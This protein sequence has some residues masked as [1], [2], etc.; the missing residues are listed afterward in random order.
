MLCSLEVSRIKPSWLRLLSVTPALFFAFSVIF[1]GHLEPGYSHVNMAVSKLGAFSAE[2]TVLMN[3]FGLFLPGILISTFRL[4]SLSS[5]SAKQVTAGLLC[6]I[7]FGIMFAGL[8]LPMD[9]KPIWGTE[10][11]GHYILAFATPAPYVVSVVCF[12]A[13]IPKLRANK[14]IKVLVVALPLIFILSSK[15]GLPSGMYQRVLLA[16]IFLWLPAVAFLIEKRG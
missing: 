9:M 16:C 7:L 5:A 13:A 1:F 8:A 15:F 11:T 3:L 14:P 4:L 12:W 2:N 10:Y 6:L